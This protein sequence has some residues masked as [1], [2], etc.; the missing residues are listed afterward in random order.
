MSAENNLI[1]DED[2]EQ[3]IEKRMGMDPLDI[4]EICNQWIESGN[5]NKNEDRRMLGYYYLT[6]VYMRT[7]LVYD[8]DDIQSWIQEGISL[9]ERNK[10]WDYL[11]RFYNLRGSFFSWFEDYVAAIETFQEALQ[12]SKQHNFQELRGKLIGNIAIVYIFIEDY[13]AAVEYLLESLNAPTDA[14]VELNYWNKVNQYFYL[15]TAYLELEEIEMAY[16]CQLDIENLIEGRNETEYFRFGILILFG[17]IA[18]KRKN[19]EEA[20]QI[21]NLLLDTKERFQYAGIYDKESYQYISL[22]YEYQKQSQVN[23]YE[24]VERVLMKMKK[25]YEKEATIRQR[26]RFFQEILRFYQKTGQ[27]ELYSE[28]AGKLLEI[29]ELDSYETGENLLSVVQVRGQIK[30]L[31]IS[32]YKENLRKMELDHLSKH[33]ELTGLLNRRGMDFYAE[34]WMEKSRLDQTFFAVGIIDVD[35]FKQINDLHGH[36]EGDDCLSI[37]GKVISK[38][39]TSQ[40]LGARYGGDEFVILFLNVSG[41]EIE[42]FAR[43][44]QNGIKEKQNKFTISQGYAYAIPQTQMRLWDYLNRADEMLY[45]VKHKSGD[46]YMIYRRS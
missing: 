8:K 6:E 33:D 13:Q 35:H 37:L 10:C 26:K 20:G 4:I 1:F 19:M 14:D 16:R 9:C 15:G 38:M 46:N 24:E 30:N 7:G 5:K 25:T 21:I 12:L 34:Q 45:Q 36:L 22:L 41:E 18:M 39:Q 28:Y 3:F 32:Q 23:Y 43:E 40:I 27:C 11:A 2:I 44:I 42:K 17:R 29:M 31:K